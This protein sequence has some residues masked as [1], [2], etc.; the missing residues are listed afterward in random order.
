MNGLS[1]IVRCEPRIDGRRGWGGL[2]YD[3]L[4]GTLPWAFMGCGGLA[5]GGSG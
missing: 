3:R 5:I 1:V 2:D 4:A